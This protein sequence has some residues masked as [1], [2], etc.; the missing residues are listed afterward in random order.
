[1]SPPR[2]PMIPSR[3]LVHVVETDV[4]L[5]LDPLTAWLRTRP[6]EIPRVLP[7]IVKSTG[8]FMRL[9][10]KYPEAARELRIL[11]REV[12]KHRMGFYDGRS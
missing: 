10:Q 3:A 4:V 11:A 12:G 6:L 5:A 1:M 2:L 9:I 7:V 8:E